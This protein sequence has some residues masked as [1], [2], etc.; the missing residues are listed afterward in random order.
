MKS[1]ALMSKS[2]FA[3]SRE[4]PLWFSSFC[5]VFFFF[6]FFISCNVFHVFLFFGTEKISETRDVKHVSPKHVTNYKF[7]SESK[8]EFSNCEKERFRS[9]DGGGDRRLWALTQTNTLS[10]SYNHIHMVFLS[11]QT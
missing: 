5:F 10:K 1:Q 4:V 11:K 8:I 9:K 3:L 2:I 6:P 7:K